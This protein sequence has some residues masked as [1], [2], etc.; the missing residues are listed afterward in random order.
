MIRAG[1]KDKPLAVDILTQSFADNKSV[2][3]IIKQ[4]QKKRSGY[5]G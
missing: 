1:Y 5:E 4:D 2:N 3:Y